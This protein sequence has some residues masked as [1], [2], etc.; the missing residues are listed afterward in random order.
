MGVTTS[1][2]SGVGGPDVQEPS[3]S[4]SVV[5]GGSGVYTRCHMR[6]N[7]MVQVEV[8]DCLDGGSGKAPELRE[9]RVEDADGC[10][11]VVRGHAACELC[12]HVGES[13]EHSLLRHP[14]ALLTE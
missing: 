8:L 1:Y 14:L 2:L 9:C 6:G 12:S 5:N 10:G 11:M 3:S 13:G 7:G 4:L